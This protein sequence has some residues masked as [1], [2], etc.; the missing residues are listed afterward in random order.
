MPDQPRCRELQ[1][2]QWRLTCRNEE[3]QLRIEECNRN[4]HALLP[5]YLSRPWERRAISRV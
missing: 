5:A 1:I 2:E 4:E 3:L